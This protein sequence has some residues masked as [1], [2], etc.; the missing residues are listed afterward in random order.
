MDEHEK[1]KAKIQ[2]K[3]DWVCQK[4]AREIDRTNC[5]EEEVQRIKERFA[6]KLVEIEREGQMAK[7]RH[8][9]SIRA[10]ESEAM[11]KVS[12]AEASEIKE[13]NGPKRC[14]ALPT[15]STLA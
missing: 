13:T 8:D 1:F 10:T 12:K 3:D 9:E 6:K 5:A 11:D 15:Y 14:I 4:L 2:E 7:L